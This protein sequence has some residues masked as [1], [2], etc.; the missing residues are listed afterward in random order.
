MER[1]PVLIESYRYSFSVYKINCCV[2][3]IILIIRVNTC[4]SAVRVISRSLCS[5]DA[6]DQWKNVLD[7]WFSPG[8]EKKWFHGGPQVDEEIRKKFGSMVSEII[9]LV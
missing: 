8:A 2:Q 6:S 4:G 1:G 7:Y 3:I 5:G 9:F